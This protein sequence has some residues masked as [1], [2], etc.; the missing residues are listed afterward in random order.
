MSPS[1]ENER[2]YDQLIQNIQLTSGLIQRLADQIKSNDVALESLR[3]ELL[4]IKDNLENISCII[5]GGHGDKPLLSR[6]DLMEQDFQ[7]V[8]KWIEEQVEKEKAAHEAKE[9]ATALEK[10]KAANRKW[11]MTI[12]IISS[13]LGFVS[14]LIVVLVRGK[15]GQ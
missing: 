8:H 5:R 11:N 10:S 3:G 9:E 4:N 1:N 13:I 15:L 14:S 12:L 6:I 2:I 7:H